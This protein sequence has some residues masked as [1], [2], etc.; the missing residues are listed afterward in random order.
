[1]TKQIAGFQ[2]ENEELSQIKNNMMIS[3][4]CLSQE[5]EVSLR[6]ITELKNEKCILHAENKDIK[7]KYKLQNIVKTSS[8]TLS[9]EPVKKR[10]E[11][12]SNSSSKSTRMASEIFGMSN[13]MGENNYISNEKMETLINNK[14]NDQVNINH[15]HNDDI[16]S[17]KGKILI[18]SGS[19]GRNLAIALN[20]Q[21]QGN[22]LTQAILKPNAPDAA[23]AETGIKNTKHFTKC[24]L[25][26]LWP[27]KLTQ[28]IKNNLLN[29]L[30]NTN[31]IIIS[32]PYNYKLNSY[33]LN[34]CVYYNNLA[35]LKA[36]HQDNL[37]RHF[38]ECNS[39]LRK[40]NFIRRGYETSLNNKGTYFLSEAIKAHMENYFGLNKIEPMSSSLEVGFTCEN[41]A[42]YQFRLSTKST[43]QEMRSART[44]E[45]PFFLGAA[46]KQGSEY[47]P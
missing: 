5:R 30:K 14:Q 19:Y 41:V 18:V 23:L 13:M 6:E 7:K 47:C 27:K 1:M 24:D 44:S 3:I 22:Y 34:E 26:I 16:K 20:R 35:L 8:S 12:N 11:D 4:E 31:T 9:I 32:E 29:N 45:D 43:V 28:N 39:I 25:V 36:L 15:L 46:R 38:L 42:P 21:M 17:D 2:L 37:Q 40:S 10:C 33:D